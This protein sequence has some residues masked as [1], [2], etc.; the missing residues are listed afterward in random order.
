MQF[1]SIYYLVVIKKIYQQKC[2]FALSSLR[3]GVKRA[4]FMR[5]GIVSKK[6]NKNKHKK[7]STWKKKC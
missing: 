7:V 1:V 6:N 2:M 4:V 3:G 5:N